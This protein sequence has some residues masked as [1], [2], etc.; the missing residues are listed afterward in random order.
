M[1]KDCK[2]VWI[3]H[4]EI[5]IGMSLTLTQTHF[6]NFVWLAYTAPQKE[7]LEALSKQYN[8]DHFTVMTCLESDHLPKMEQHGDYNF[9]IL[10]V[11]SAKQHQNVTTV[12]ALSDKIAFFYNDNLLVTIHR[13]D[14]PFINEVRNKCTLNSSDLKVE[15]LMTSLFL[16]IFKTYKAPAEWQSQQMNKIEDIIFLEDLH[17]ISLEN[18]YYQKTETRISKKLLILSQDVIHQFHTTKRGK[19]ELRYVHDL[20]SKLIL[21]YDEALE[22]AHNLMHT[23]MSVSAQKNNDTMK[24]LTIVSMFFLPLTFIVGLYGMNFEFMPE[25]HWEY[26]YPLSLLFMVALC[27]FIYYIFK[28]RKVI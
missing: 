1:E 18:L 6:D 19:P 12:Q 13:V 23:Y 21:E 26:G 28:R 7:D 17:K 10:R 15:E 16:Q 4:L 3:Q 2:F 5:A 11:Y 9:M 20:L 27:G 8:L 24:L 22:D 25:L 14:F